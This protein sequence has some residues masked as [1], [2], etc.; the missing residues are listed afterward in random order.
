MLNLHGCGQTY[1][2]LAKYGNWESTANEKQM[3]VVV[4]MAP[5]W[6]RC[7]GLLGLLWQS[8]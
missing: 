5:T 8:T 3:I 6:G 2:Q 7:L 4:P 1:E